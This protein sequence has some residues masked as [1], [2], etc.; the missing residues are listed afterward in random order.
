MRIRCR[1][2]TEK[3]NQLI[4]NS[5]GA[6]YTCP[7]TRFNSPKSLN[8]PQKISG[9]DKQLWFA[10]SSDQSGNVFAGMDSSIFRMEKDTRVK[11]APWIKKS[12]VIHRVDAADNTNGDFP[13]PWAIYPVTPQ[14]LLIGSENQGL[15]IYHLSTQQLS[16][17]AT[18]NAFPELAKAGVMAIQ[19]DREGN[20]WICASTGFYRL[21][22]EKGIME[23]HWQNGTQENHLPHSNFCHFYEDKEGVFWLASNGGGLIHWDKKKGTST[24]LARK[25]GFPSN[26]LYAVYE[27]ENDHLWI[28]S[29]SG[30]IQFDKKMSAVSSVYLTEDGI[31]DNE[32]NR[33]SHFKGADGTLYFGGLNGVT[34]FQPNDFY[35]KN[36]AGSLPLVVTHFQQFD[37]NTNQLKDKTGDLVI[38]NE[39]VLHPDDRFFNLEF[40]LLSFTQT[41]HIQYAFKMEGV[42]ADWTYQN[43]PVLQL[44]RLP[45]GTHILHIKGQAA[46]GTWG[47][48][49]LNIKVKVLR[50]FYLQFWFLLLSLLTISLTIRF[51]FKWRTKELQH[52]QKLLQKEV[53]LQTA[54]FQGQ[55]E[56][57]RQLDTL[58]TR[59]YT[60]ITHAF[61]TPLTVILGMTDDIE[62][63]EKGNIPVT[64]ATGLIRRNGKNLLR[65]INQLLDLSKLDS[66][67]M[68]T[69]RVKTDIISYLQYLTES[70]YSLAQDKKVRLIFYPEIPKLMMD[71]DEEKLQIIIYNL[72]S[73][74]FKFTDNGGK[75]VL[76]ATQTGEENTPFL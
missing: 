8:A 29:S 58:K 6:I 2:I 10:L 53:L 47:S 42:D 71:F 24:Q 1:G 68:K 14:Q 54:K 52:N 3:D 37:G 46:N 66:G 73:N 51:F 4:F 26:T 30:L 70:F 16:P 38:R 21:D 25:A 74:A 5:Q 41:D 59:L 13:T 12:L 39:I 48:N 64:Y 18:Y 49:E 17:Y 40:A 65:L 55:T 23:R 56:E 76:H 34:A 32:F 72:L 15:Q 75:V 61:R 35:E 9:T 69:H 57:L 44:S 7:K 63:S 62:A 31:T 11:D 60:N 67:T 36:N 45:Y 33:I 28:P 43:K 20:I 27:D 50:P 22:L 19:P